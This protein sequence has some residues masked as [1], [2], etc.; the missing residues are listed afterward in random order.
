MPTPS[1]LCSPSEDES[2][3]YLV[4]ISH[5][6]IEN[7]CIE[8]VGVGKDG[9]LGDPNDFSMMGW[10]TNSA[11]PTN[12]GAGL[13]TCHKSFSSVPEKRALC[14]QLDEVVEGAEIIVEISSGQKF[15]YYVDQV[16]T[17][18]L[19]EVNMA[20]FQDVFGEASH[21]INLMTCAGNWD[22]KIGDATHRLMVWAT[23]D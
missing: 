13:Y 7:V 8:P 4:T 12:V 22:T 19:S 11:V 23:R 17:S 14:D 9:T 5:I 2:Q 21:G 1:D 15:T 20:E 18:L 6:G 16:K 3:P 10:Y